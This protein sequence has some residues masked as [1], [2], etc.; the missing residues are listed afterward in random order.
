MGNPH[1]TPVPELSVVAFDFVDF[2]GFTIPFVVA[3][4]RQRNGKWR[5]C[6]SWHRQHDQRLRDNLLLSC[7]SSRFAR[8]SFK[9][10]SGY[11]PRARS[12][13]N[14]PNEYF[15]RQSLAPEGE[16]CRKRPRV[17]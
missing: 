9:P 16:I 5:A 4:H 1:G 17:S 8:A 14:P 6:F 3:T 2:D 15:M 11:R 10:I 12:F 13:R 7:A